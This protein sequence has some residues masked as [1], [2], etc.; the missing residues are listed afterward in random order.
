MNFTQEQL[1]NH[2]FC[3]SPLYSKSTM[4]LTAILSFLESQ[5][6]G[7]GSDRFD[8]K[9]STEQQRQFFGKI[10]GHG[11]ITINWLTGEITHRV[12]ARFSKDRVAQDYVSAR[13][14]LYA[15]V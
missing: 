6:A 14:Y 1:E 12:K 5:N 10:Y 2:D 13:D 8:G 7:R 3:S 15:A 9:L 11:R 4:N